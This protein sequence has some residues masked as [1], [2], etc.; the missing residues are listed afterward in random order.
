MASDNGTIKICN[1]VMY[2]W[3]VSGRWYLQQQ[4]LY[5]YGFAQPVKLNFNKRFYCLSTLYACASQS[6]FSD[7]IF[8]IAPKK[9]WGAHNFC[10]VLWSAD[11]QSVCLLLCPIHN[12]FLCDWI[13]DSANM[14]STLRKH[15][16]CKIVS[17]R[18]K[19]KVTEKLKGFYGGDIYVLLVTFLI[20]HEF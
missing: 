9:N 5:Y 17:I 15:G 12:F 14:L 10:L 19:F 18:L 7:I 6:N 11:C 4:I 3:S 16:M 1:S 13:S 2:Y 20:M 8:F